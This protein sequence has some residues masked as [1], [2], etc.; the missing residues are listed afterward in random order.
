MAIDGENVAASLQAAIDKLDSANEVVL[1]FSAVPRIDADALKA[2]EN[3]AGVAAAKAA[4]I[5]L[6]GVQV[7]V[8]RVLM[9]AKLTPRFAFAD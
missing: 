3:L 2:M 4:K 6:C 1:D 9:L 8:Y 7:D 5:V